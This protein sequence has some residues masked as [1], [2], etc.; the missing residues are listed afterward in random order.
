MAKVRG[1]TVSIGTTTDKLRKSLSEIHSNLS[2][3]DKDLK[4]VNKGLKFDSTNQDMLV[5]KQSLINKEID[6]TNKKLEVLK[7]T[8]KEMENDTSGNV[9]EE[10]IKAI[11]FEIAKTEQQLNSFKKNLKEIDNIKLNN[12]ANNFNSVGKSITK[13]VS[14]PIAT[15]FT[16]MTKS[17][18]DFETAFSG[19]RKTVD[20]SDEEFKVLEE[21]IKNLSTVIPS[22]AS[23]I[24]KVGEIAGQ[25]GISKD[26]ILEFSEVMINMGVATNLSAE[27]AST[28][29]ARFTNIMKSS[30]KD[31]ERI[32]SVIVSLGNNFATTETDITEMSLRLAGASKQIKLSEDEVLAFA[33]ALSSVGIE[34][35]AGGSAFSKLM[36]KIDTL[37]ATN[38]KEL[39]N[40]AEVS[41]MSIA[42][43]KKS[44]GEDSSQVLLNFI[45]GLGNVEASGKNATV[46]LEDLGITEVRLRDTILR[47]ANASD[48]FT[49]A[50]ELGNKA[51][52]EN[53]ALQA[54]ADKKYKT[55]ESQIEM[56]KNQAVKLGISFGNIVIPK[57]QKTLSWFQ[58]L[59][60]SIDKMSPATKSFI[61]DLGLLAIA[62]GPVLI[63]I[64]KMI[65]SF[66]YLST[67]L[68][69]SK[70]ALGGV[71]GAVTLLIPLFGSLI[72]LIKDSADSSSVFEENFNKAKETMSVFN[73]EID[74]IET[75]F[76]TSMT[77]IDKSFSNT[78]S[79][80]SDTLS[81]TD[82]INKQKEILDSID[83]TYETHKQKILDTYSTLIE[84]SVIGINNEEEREKIINDL[85]TK[86]K[87]ELDTLKGKYSETYGKISELTGK[88]GENLNN[89]SS[90][91][92]IKLYELQNEFSG[93]SSS[94]S[95]LELD[96]SSLTDSMINDLESGREVSSE[97]LELFKDTLKSKIAEMQEDI[98]QEIETRKILISNGYMVEE[99]AKIIEDLETKKENLITSY[100]TIIE[101]LAASVSNSFKE[102][103]DRFTYNGNILTPEQLEKEKEADKKYKSKLLEDTLKNTDAFI[104]ETS[105]SLYEGMKEV[106]KNAY[107]GFNG[108]Y[109]S[110]DY[111]N[112]GKKNAD[113]YEIG[114]RS[115]LGIKSPS[116]KMKESSKNTFIGFKFNSDKDYSSLGIDNATAYLDSMKKTL[117]NIENIN[118]PITNS[119]S[120]N[121]K[122]SNSTSK[123]VNLTV[124]AQS[125]SDGEID[126]LVNKINYELGKE[127]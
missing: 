6:E 120:S 2:L 76:T 81:K 35:E 113:N 47:S 119:N 88:N 46:V 95:N 40:W 99:N 85:R 84:A 4:I 127:L 89:A 61:V 16:L 39:K 108:K 126:R 83:D 67:T 70:L 73:D 1:L 90:E 56:T 8:K 125:L 110:Q 103:A 79:S 49:N 22:S 11:N 124:N 43:F 18:I 27:E 64:S 121:P 17:A 94:M 53:N 112:L 24:A 118:L 25:L 50:L 41:N 34:A 116:K 72:T 107:D 9:T 30:S 14:L 101:D 74:N 38:S 60:N 31:Y 66:T 115:G 75:D 26:S 52:V 68:N 78:L 122:S 42:D 28:S 111:Y 86:E 20:A 65:T 82:L 87:R 3:I 5:Q 123:I 37:V 51:W 80:L 100:N 109:K 21:E 12:I 13:N 105:T 23:E 33:A 32:G 58:K 62:T 36:L 102:K 104:D 92:I 69:L 44:W 96:L 10:N 29:I 77:N 114:F 19:V 97:Q 93:F 59:T 57:V 7:N 106:N 98:Q 55:T 45:K 63:G 54:E 71:V 15:A 48:V 91:I 117:N